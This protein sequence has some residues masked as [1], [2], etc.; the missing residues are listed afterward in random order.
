MDRA[1]RASRGDTILQ[2]SLIVE[3][4]LPVDR[5][6]DDDLE[7]RERGIQFGEGEQD[8]IA[9]ARTGEH[10]GGH[11]VAP[12][13]AAER[14]TGTL[15]ELADEHALWHFTGRPSSSLTSTVVR[16]I[17]LSSAGEIESGVRT[18]PAMLKGAA[19]VVSC[20]GGLGAD[21]REKQGTRLGT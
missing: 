17:A 2:R 12:H 10:I 8:L 3:E 5:V 1:G 11:G 6:R 9:V 18:S 19:A 4:Q 16:G 21:E 20:G 7:A 15:Q 13:V 14:R